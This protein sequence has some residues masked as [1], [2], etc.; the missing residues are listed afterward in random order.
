MHAVAVVVVQLDL[1]AIAGSLKLGQPVPDSNFVSDEN[2]AVPQ[3]AHRYVP[4]PSRTRT[5]R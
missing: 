4:S 2:S 3:A 1:R 5:V